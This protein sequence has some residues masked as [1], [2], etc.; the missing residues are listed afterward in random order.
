MNSKTY[1]NGFRVVYEKT[2][3]P[4][5]ITSLQVFCDIGSIHEPDESRG[6]AHFI[7]HMCFKGT[8]KLKTAKEVNLIF[9]KTGSQSNAYTDRRYTCYYADT[10][11]DNA[12]LCISTLADMLLNSVFDKTEYM[13]ERDVVREEM[14]KDADDYELLALENADKQIYAGSPYEHPVD[15]LKYHEGKHALKYENILEIYKKFYIPTNFILSVCSSLSFETVC[16]YVEQSDFTKKVAKIEPRPSINLCIKPQSDVVYCLEKRA[17]NQVHICIGFRTCSLSNPDKYCLKLLKTILSGKINSR[18]FMLLREENGLTYTSYAYSDFFE[19]MGDFKMYAEC[20]PA[21][22]FKNGSGPGVF[23]L[24]CQMICDLLE[25]GVT[26]DELLTAKG[27]SQGVQKMNAE[28]SSVIAK[29]N[30]K[31]Q[32]FNNLSA[33][34]YAD[35]YKRLIEPITQADIHRC[36]RQ[37]FCREGMVVSIVSANL[38]VKSKLSKFVDKVWA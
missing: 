20:D 27:F 19:H 24:L 8:T 22:V 23:P 36:I 30:G 38:I 6:S 7:E 33:P 21:K 10:D 26:K 18:M 25:H 34:R 14:V 11:K 1:E 3:I 17:T 2:S 37:Y 29:Y 28:N 4:S 31:N 35:K 16:K 32:L 9:D 15:E 13:K 5:N 12:R